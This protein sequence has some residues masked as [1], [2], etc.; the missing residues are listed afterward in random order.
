MPFNR[1][2]RKVALVHVLTN[3]LEQDKDSPMTLALAEANCN[4]IN[5]LLTMPPDAIDALFFVR[6]IGKTPD[7]QVKLFPPDCHYLKSLVAYTRWR[8]SIGKP[9]DTLAE[10]QAVTLDDFGLFLETHSYDEEFADPAAHTL[11]ARQP[12]TKEENGALHLSK[13]STNRDPSRYPVITDD[14]SWKKWKRDFTSAARIDRVNRLLDPHFFPRPGKDTELFEE[15]QQYLFDVLLWTLQTEKGKAMVRKH[16]EKHDAQRTCAEIFKFW[17]TSSSTS[18]SSSDLKKRT[19]L[20][21]SKKEECST[22]TEAFVN[23]SQKQVQLCKGISSVHENTPD[24]TTQHAVS[25]HDDSSRVNAM[26]AANVLINSTHMVYI[27]YIR[28]FYRVLLARSSVGTR[29]TDSSAREKI[30]YSCAPHNVTPSI[31]VGL[32]LQNYGTRPLKT[33]ANAMDPRTPTPTIPYTQWPSP[34]SEAQEKG[35]SLPTS[36]KATIL[37][38]TYPPNAGKR[39]KDNPSSNV[40]AFAPHA[41]ILP[42]FNTPGTVDVY[43]DPD[44]PYSNEVS[45]KKHMSKYGNSGGNSILEDE[46]EIVFSQD[47]TSVFDPGI[48]LWEATHFTANYGQA[49][50]DAYEEVIVFYNESEDP[51]M[52][53]RQLFPTVQT[54]TPVLLDGE[55]CDTPIRHFPTFSNNMDYAGANLSQ[56]DQLSVFQLGSPMNTQRGMLSIPK[57]DHTIML[58]NPKGL[59]AVHGESFAIANQGEK[60]HQVTNS[61]LPHADTIVQR[62]LFELR[63]G[64]EGDVDD[65]PKLSSFIQ[66][67][68]SYTTWNDVSSLRNPSAP[69]LVSYYSTFTAQALKDTSTLPTLYKE[70]SYSFIET[71]LYDL[72][73]GSEGDIDDASKDPEAIQDDLLTSKPKV[74]LK[75]A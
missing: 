53:G 28:A 29:S 5:T 74:K 59:V 34:F 69:L 24:P 39:D 66:P 46:E 27:Q 13:R 40:D 60:V 75:R 32:T 15:Q 48:S 9:L 7:N 42:G 35:T 58:N 65:T 70:S 43:E 73:V 55:G 57:P 37:G 30:W 2:Q 23:D 25:G 4:E 54:K 56:E 67:T 72:R 17:S 18:L 51:P 50:H 14:K 71:D 64:S 62:S 36:D 20:S 47:S 33:I 21:V 31:Q 44:S 68:P 8:G 38:H 1:L 12:T 10:W 22:T 41:T 26:P 49:N 61:Q 11:S 52:P 63:I 3:V 16:Q 19:I 6:K 45:V